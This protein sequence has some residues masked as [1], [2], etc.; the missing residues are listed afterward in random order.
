MAG[1]VGTEND[2]PTRTHEER[3]GELREVN[4][5]LKYSS[6]CIWPLDN[7]KRGKTGGGLGEGLWRSL[8][9]WARGW[10]VDGRRSRCFGG[11]HSGG[12][13]GDIMII[14]RVEARA[15]SESSRRARGVRSIQ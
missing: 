13:C 5:T 1:C 12:H 9:K 14:R 11:D 8:E 2:E 3:I 10:M 4:S 7:E 6:Q 15:V